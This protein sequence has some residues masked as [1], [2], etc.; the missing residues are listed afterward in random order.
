MVSR[1]GTCSLRQTETSKLLLLSP[2]LARA[3]YRDCELQCSGVV[4]LSLVDLLHDV[5]TEPFLLVCRH[6]CTLS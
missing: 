4:L 6:H 2:W 5:H 3:L 1:F